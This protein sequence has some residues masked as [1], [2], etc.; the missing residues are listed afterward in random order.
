V[1]AVEE[2]QAGLVHQHVLITAV[3]LT[4]LPL[5][6]DTELAVALESSGLIAA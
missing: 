3:L 5:L 4:G 2:A 1:S 6:T